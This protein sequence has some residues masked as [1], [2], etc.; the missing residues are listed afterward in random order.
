M[1][2]G[3]ELCDYGRLRKDSELK[4]QAS[5]GPSIQSIRPLSRSTAGYGNSSVEFTFFGRFID[6]LDPE[7]QPGSGL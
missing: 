4:I 6:V 2:P 1:P 3:H 5:D 7:N